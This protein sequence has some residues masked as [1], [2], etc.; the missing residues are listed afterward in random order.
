MLVDEVQPWADSGI[1]FRKTG[2]LCQI[3][4]S[5]KTQISKKEEFEWTG[6]ENRNKN[7]LMNNEFK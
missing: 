2:L 6:K 4:N 1:A 7:I 5:I 3:S